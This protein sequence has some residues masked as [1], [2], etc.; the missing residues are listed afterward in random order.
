[1]NLR[2]ILVTLVLIVIY[3]G[4]VLFRVRLSTNSEYY[5]ARD[6]TA[7]YWTENALQ[8]H[9]AELIANGNS[10]PDFDPKLQAS[11]GVKIFENLTILMEYPCGWLYRFLNLKEKNLLFHTWAIIFIACCSSLGIFAIFALC[12][13]LKMN[14]FY[15]ILAGLLLN[16]SLVA[17]GRSIFGFLNEDFVLPF[18]FFGLSAY[19][20]AIRNQQN[21]ILFSLIAGFCFLIS[22]AGWHFSRFIFLTVIICSVLNLWIFERN[23]KTRINISKILFFTLLI[24]FLGSL[25]VPVLK[26]RLYL[27]SPA[28]AL[29][30]GAAIGITF[31]NPKNEK[32]LIYSFSGW[33]SMIPVLILLPLSILFSRLM[34]IETEYL[35]VWSLIIAKMKFLGIKPSDPE[36][37]DYPARSLWIEAFNS[38]HPVS[39]F[40]NLFPII[41]PA[42]W[43]F[44][45]L[46]KHRKSENHIRL[47]LFL[48]LTFFLSYLAIERMG[49]VNNFLVVTL[50]VSLCLLDSGKL[51]RPIKILI[52]TGLTGIFLFN[53]CQCYH[54][55]KPTRYIGLLRAVF[56]NE[57]SENIYNWRL[58]NIE[59]V[60]FVRFKT[61]ENATF[62]SSFGV[63]PLIFA[64]AERAIALQPKF[65][66][67]DCQKMVKEFFDVIYDS[68]ENFY[69]LCKKR[70]IDYFV[71][72]IK[73]LLDNSRDGSRWIAG[74]KEVST[75]S[76]AFLMHFFPET[77][78]HFE[79]VYQNNFYR[80]YRVLGEDE[81]TQTGDFQYQPIYDIKVYGNQEKI[82]KIFD[83]RYTKY[84]I[85]DIKQA[86]LLLQKANMLLGKDPNQAIHLMEKS[87]ALYPSLIGSVTT[88]GIA[89]ALTG[90]I[91]QGLLL[92]QQEVKD[93]YLYPLGH[94]NLAYCLYLKGDISGALTELRETLRFDPNFVDALEM[95]KQLQE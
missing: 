84:I 43:G 32:P 51:R 56:G 67:K 60:R 26:S 63:G 4:S 30:F 80:L 39:L 40:K 31:L 70:Q 47:L 34:A 64:Y 52:P 78:K 90:K 95:V 48:S 86:K 83:D 20:Y 38:P 45:N 68:E 71:Y 29:G 22:L 46:L 1:M 11:D 89:Y 3:F 28:F 42:V 37:L 33:R 49:V 36:I 91:E 7:F 61:P 77:L 62:L 16:F 2:N 74:K 81:Y 41:I 59:L 69:L 21:S 93:N 15:S 87:I 8:Y 10:I 27:F 19:F 85:N 55:H 25:L 44:M 12:R 5:D 92:C 58:N 17:V 73:I 66:V 54:L 72:D 76:V 57:I 18:I 13:A 24:P 14:Y 75:N 53:F 9:Y 88:L 6:P 35:H 65:E 23:P 79:L 50:S 82:D 94:Y